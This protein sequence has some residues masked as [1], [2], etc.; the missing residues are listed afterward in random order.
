MFGP[1]GRAYVYFSYGVHWMLN[2]VTQP[3]GIAEA[4]LIQS[5]RAILAE[6]G[7]ANIKVEINSIG[8]KDSIARFY[9]DLVSYYRKHIN[10][11]NADCRQL[12][13]RDPFE[14]L[15]SRDPKCT[16]VRPVSV[17]STL[18]Q[19]EL[20]PD[21]ALCTVGLLS[22]STERVG[23]SSG[24]VRRVG[25]AARWARYAPPVSPAAPCHLR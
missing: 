17:A 7:Y 16:A 10:D 5:A 23:P 14:L 11:M 18:L 24:L 22:G 6:E 21:L 8:D 3:E 19:K 12:F 9:R 15:S 25:L 2:F 20:I 13:K 4:I 1:P